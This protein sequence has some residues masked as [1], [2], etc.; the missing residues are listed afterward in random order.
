MKCL[1]NNIIYILPIA[2]HLFLLLQ[3]SFF[4]YPEM[5]VYSYLTENGLL[6]Y[7]QIT[8][9]HF[10][11]LMFLPVNFYSLG[12]DTVAEMRIVHIVL[13]VLTD[14]VFIAVLKKVFKKNRHVFIGLTLYIFWQLYFEGHVL[15]IESFLTP[16]LL[17]AFGFLLIYFEKK[18]TKHLYTTSLLLGTALVFKQTVVPLTALIFLYLLIK[19]VRF[20]ELFI[21]GI[22]I[23]APILLVFLYFYKLGVLTDFI[24]WTLTFNLTVF[25]EMGKTKPEI[26]D[27]LKLLPTFGVSMLYITYIF[28]KQYLYKHHSV[29]LNLIRDLVT[30]IRKILPSRMVY[31]E[32]G[33]SARSQNNK[34]SDLFSGES[35]DVVN[36]VGI[37]FI[38][39]LFFAYARFDYIH[40]QPALPF[41]VIILSMLIVNLSIMCQVSSIKYQVSSFLLIAFRVA[42]SFAYCLLSLFIFVP[43]FR[44]NNHPGV[45]PM[46]NDPETLELVSTVKNI[47]KKNEKIFAI[48]TY[49]HI[50]YLTN[51]IPS[52]SFFTFQFSWF[53]IVN[54]NRVYRGIIEDPPALIVR[55][56]TSEVGGYRLSDYMQNINRY[57]NENYEMVNKVNNIEILIKI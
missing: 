6:P 11:G 14:V 43:Y 5:F 41:A 42:L 25:N 18:K 30:K 27:V 53:M 19:K 46:L 24:Y 56:A 37:Y 12:I 47:T 28:I 57:I 26:T 40:L 4:P 3:M 31:T 36:L 33:R 48:G 55:D 8:D 32:Q 51:T 13:T 15:W 7:K 17:S 10:P 39:C 29:I 35:Y 52:G 44:F 54:E 49:P 21:S 20:R 1:K 22:I 34:G 45:S 23:S 2:I 9:Q 50:Y 16:L 38:G